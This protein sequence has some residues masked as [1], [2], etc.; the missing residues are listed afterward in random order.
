MHISTSEKIQLNKEAIFRINTDGTVV[1]M[2]MD[3]DN[4][5]F[6]ITGLAASIWKSLSEEDKSLDEIAFQVTNEYD[7]SIDQARLDSEEFIKK[8][9][10]LDLA[11]LQ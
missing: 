5:F 10:Q 6:K 11:K 7:V 1:V 4:N 9:V 3:D 8:L 2:K